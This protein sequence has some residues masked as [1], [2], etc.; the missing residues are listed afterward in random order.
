[1]VVILTLLILSF[2][3]GESDDG[4]EPLFNG[5]DLEGWHVFAGDE[6]QDGWSV[7]EGVLIF[8]FQDK[9]DTK[10]SNLVTDKTFSNFELSLEWKISDQGNSGLFW[11][12]VEDG[13]YD[14]PYQTGPEIQ[15]LDD[16]WEEYIQERGDINRAG[17][18][19]GLLPPSKIMSKG[20]GEWNHFLLHI[21]YKNNDGFLEFNG[22]EVIKFPLHGDKWDSLVANSS[23]A[24]WPGFGKSPTGHISLQDHGGWVEFRNIK[25]RE[26]KDP[27]RE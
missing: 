20:A 18:L 6:T 2:G 8:D 17:S 13:S 15:I 12:V 19:Y 10:S 7:T 9:V 11:G 3:C 16:N 24:G 1:M 4:W 21:D 5:K 26:L 27:Q 25:I 23:F 14:H 22:Q